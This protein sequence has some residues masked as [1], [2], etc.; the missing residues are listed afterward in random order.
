MLFRLPY[1][2]GVLTCL[3][4]GL[5]AIGSPAQ[6]PSGPPRRTSKS[7]QTAELQASTRVLKA[8]SARSDVG[9]P[10]V[11]LNQTKCLVVLP[12][13]KGKPTRISGAGVSTCRET[14][15]QWGAPSFV[16]F[17]GRG[18][19]AQ[20]GL[21]I[22]ILSESGTR[23][24]DSGELRIGSDARTR[25]P[26]VRRGSAI[27]QTELNAELLTYQSSAG[28]L[29]SS[30]ASGTIQVDSVSGPT[31]SGISAKIADSYR[32]SV[33]S[34]FNTIIPTG[35]VLHHTAVIPGQDTV[36]QK[37][38]DIDEY[39]RER[40]FEILCSGRVYHV[41]YHYLVMSNGT[42]KAGRP[43]RCEGAHATGYNS[44]LGISVVGDFSSE[45]NPSGDKGPIRPSARQMAS[46]ARLCRRLRRRYE[47]SLRRIVRH[48]DV[49]NTQC[50]GDRFPFGSLI[51]SL[52]PRS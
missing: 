40:G 5:S 34:F 12:L 42:V 17:Q 46:L 37:E 47:I 6:E 16:Q 43:E 31:S 26:V 38:K 18:V 3:M 9:I 7:S 51:N 21:I 41:A 24:L 36:P 25:A 20:T 23:T 30:Q 8:I 52:G 39:H 13:L 11:V 44:Y 32:S 1:R 27:D 15:S 29:S 45:D 19:R 10:D 14:P 4:I 22:F 48:S 33:L 49:A 28:G 35:I 50:P 2:A